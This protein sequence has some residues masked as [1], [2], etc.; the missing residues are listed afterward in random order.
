M[1]KT[2]FFRRLLPLALAA[3]LLLSTVPATAVFR[4]TTGHWAESTLSEWQD[5][6]LINGYSDG[7]FRPDSTITRAEFIKLV[8]QALGFTAESV[9]SFSDVKESDWFYTEVS[10]A[11]AAGYAQGSGGAFR[12]GQS[13]TRAEAA[14]MLARALKLAADETRAE[15]FAD[16]AVFPAWAKDSIGAVAEAAYMTGYPDGTFGADSLITRAEAVVTL[17]RVRKNAQDTVIEKAGTTLENETVTGDLIITAS[18]GEGNVTLKNVTVLGDL[19]VR[20]GGAHSV[21]L[22]GI[23]VN[24][25]VLLQKE[26]VHLRLMGDTDLGSVKISQPCRITQ[27]KSFEGAVDALVINLENAP[28]KNVQIDIPVTRME[29]LS[30]GNVVLGADVETLLLSKDAEGAQLEVK[31]GA[32]V[33]ELTTDAKVE[34]TGSGTVSSLVVSASDVTVSGSLS[35]K[36]TE[37]TDGAKEPTVSGGSSGSSSGGSYTPVKRVTG[38]ETVADVAVPYGTSEADAMSHFPDSVALNVTEGGTAG[39]VGAAV[40]WVLDKAYNANPLAD[41]VYTATGTVTI[42]D[43]YIYDGTLTVTTTLTVEA[44]PSITIVSISEVTGLEL[45]NGAVE[46]DARLPVKVTVEPEQGDALL[47]NVTWTLDGEWASPGVNTYKGTVVMPDGYY[48]NGETTATI[49]TTVTVMESGATARAKLVVN[50]IPLPLTSIGYASTE[51]LV[52]AAAR[53]SLPTNILLECQDES[54]IA[55]TVPADDWRFTYTPYYPNSVTDQTLSLSTNAAL[56]VGYDDNNGTIRVYCSVEVKKLD[57]AALNSALTAAK[58]QLD[59]LTDSED[60]ALADSTKIYVA[61]NGTSADKVTKG[62]QFVELSQTT[63]LESAY[64]AA[65]D[66]QNSDTFASQAECDRLAQELREASDAFGKITPNVGT[67]YTDALLLEAVKNGGAIDPKYS[68]EFAY[69]AEMQPLRN[70]YTYWLN[71]ASGWTVPDSDV[72]VSIDWSFSG[73]GAQYLVIAADGGHDHK[74]YMHSY[75]VRVAGQPDAPAAVTFTA[76]VKRYDLD[77]NGTAVGKIDYTATIG[78]PIRVDANADVTA[79][80]MTSTIANNISLRVP[81]TGAEYITDIDTSEITIE[82]NEDSTAAPISINEAFLTAGE[83][84]TVNSYGLFVPVTASCGTMALKPVLTDSEDGTP[85]LDYG[86][87]KIKITIQPE[88]LTVK[89]GSGWY[90]P[91]GDLTYDAEVWGCNPAITIT[92]QAAT[93]GNS[94]CRNVTVQIEYAY[95]NFSGAVAYATTN[96]DQG[97]ITTAD[98]FKVIF[99]ANDFQKGA[100]G[101]ELITCTKQNVPLTF[102]KDTTYYIWCNFNGNLSTPGDWLNTNQQLRIEGETQ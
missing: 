90:V 71:G 9:V 53:P 29:I 25:T 31:R 41:T 102:L 2:A 85:K 96:S 54:Y 21:Y 13:I 50:H 63:A 22:D 101:Q 86:I 8:N 36:E 30:K 79:P 37:T 45:P 81:L 52:L 88:A 91:A 84:C 46:S 73:D 16:A 95:K 57:T 24:G 18:V 4:D 92:T 10:K 6:G 59:T 93:N 68:S 76:T 35:V 34:L 17:D 100:S 40:S 28:A 38:A 49:T 33:G 1:K 82:G 80:K 11:A 3:V 43:G 23:K 55:V 20:G 62:V 51:E 44:D 69:S 14:V 74:N 99:D 65:R 47:A 87:G 77:P 72:T 78:A 5:K 32:T 15:A 66:K 70:G 61:P 67:F 58:A 19:I 39:T 89:E 42:P 94:A 48:Y 97:A 64:T 75:G 83:S 7:S 12:P 98:E 56:P 26:N 27:D 60:D